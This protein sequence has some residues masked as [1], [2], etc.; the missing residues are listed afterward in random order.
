M[1]A[2]IK[3]RIAAINSGIIPEGYKKTK[4]G[5]VPVEWETARFDKIATKFDYG[6]NAAAKEFDGENKYIRITDIDERSNKYSFSDVVSP[7][8]ELDEDYLVKENDILFARTGASTG[9]TYLYNK[10]DG[11]MFFAG[12]LI[13]ANIHTQNNAYFIFSQTLTERYDNWVRIFSMRSGQ[14]GINAQ[15]YKSFEVLLPPLPEQQKIAEILST[16]D[17][18]IELQEKKIEQLKELK[19]AYLQKMFPQKGS[20]Y[21]ELRF[22]GFTDPWEQRKLGEI[23]TFINGRAY[24]QDEL[25][26][27]GKYK[28]LRVGNFYTNDSWYYSDMELEDKYY[29]EKGDLLYTWSATFGPHIWRGDK[30]IYHYHIWKVELS[31]HLEKKF[32]VQLLEQDKAAI[33][34]D[35]NGST[36][37]HITKAG[38]EEK[39]VII[40]QNIDEQEK[41]GTF[42][43]NLDNLITLHQRKSEQEKQ[44][45]KALMQ[46]LLTGIVRT[47]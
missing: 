22:K 28:V 26:S 7:D 42:L 16:Q 25:L 44:K 1:N 11:K 30:V 5:I 40:P 21:P 15:E 34:S 33:F 10:D 31:Q 8:C 38:M 45:K 3:E 35:K 41:I 39:A 6:L 4:V 18:L 46:L 23:A 20:K 13:R 24:S 43:N 32:A 12:F 37:V 29:A 17:K 36:M 2:E 27:S 9:K 19:K 47:K 14:S